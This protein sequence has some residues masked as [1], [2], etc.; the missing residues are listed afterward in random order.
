MSLPLDTPHQAHDLE[1]LK[2]ALAAATRRAEEAERRI[3]TQELEAGAELLT[4]ATDELHRSERMLRAIFGGATDAMLLLDDEGSFVDVNPAACAL[5]KLGKPALL[6]CT[7][8]D[9][10]DDGPEASRKMFAAMKE[11]G[12]LQ[13]RGH[14]RRADGERRAVDMSAVANV[15]LG[16]HLVLVRDVTEEY[17]AAESLAWTEEELRRSDTRFRAMVEKSA[18]AI[19]LLSADGRIEYITRH[20]YDFFGVT[21]TQMVG[22]NAFTWVTPEDRARVSEAFSSSAE[23]GTQV[24]F[25]IVDHRGETRW[26]EAVVTN[27]LPDPA[28]GAIVLNVRDA[29]ARHREARERERLIETLTFERQRLGQLLQEAPAFIAVLRGEDLVFELANGAYAELMGPHRELV[30]KPLRVALPEIAAQGFVEHCAEVMR[31]GVPWSKKSGAV[32]I[33]RKGPELERHYTKATPPSSRGCWP[34]AW[35]S[36]KSR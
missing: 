21:P 11:S 18:E 32:D 26:L 16:L 27:L 33:A 22:S 9:F 1:Q 28:I 17:A 8:G 13:V 15:G 34:P 30:G 6:R 24:E 19:A 3:A 20:S 23:T 29:T 14:L 5:L 36:C 2:T 10:A 35:L 7:I 31:T 12:Q 4:L 25:R